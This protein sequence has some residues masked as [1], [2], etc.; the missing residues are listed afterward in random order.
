[1]LKDEISTIEERLD[2][3][4]TFKSQIKE[5]QNET[6]NSRNKIKELE[7]E[8]RLSTNKENNLKDE[9]RALIANNK[10]IKS[11]L[12]SELNEKINILKE[13]ENLKN[14]QKI[15]YEKH[16]SLKN[17]IENTASERETIESKLKSLTIK[18]E[19]L[20]KDLISIQQ[21]SELKCENIF[22]QYQLLLEEKEML[23]DKLNENKFSDDQV[24]KLSD[25]YEE[26]IF[27]LKCEMNVWKRSFLDIANYKLTNFQEDNWE[28][29]INLDKNYIYNCPSQLSDKANGIVTYFK[30]L[31]EEELYKTINLKSLKNSLVEEQEKSNYLKQRLTQETSLRRKIHNR[32]MSIR[33]NLRVMCRVRPFTSNEK[34]SLLKK[35]FLD[36]FSFTTDTISIY[37]K[38]TYDLDYVFTQKSQQSD[39]YEE[40]S[41]LTQSMLQGNNICVI[42]YGQTCTGKTY[43]ILGQELE[44]SF[45]IAVRTAAELFELLS[46]EPH[47]KK[48]TNSN[49]SCISS[50]KLTLSII[51]IYNEGIFN[52]LDSSQTVLNIFENS[53]GNLVIPDLH[54]IKINSFSEAAK[55]FKLAG[56]FR[57]TNS[58]YYNERSSRSHC[59]YTFSVKIEKGDKIIRSKMH[60]IDLAGSERIT[61][62]SYLKDGVNYMNNKENFDNEELIKKEAISINLSLHALSNVLNALSM[63]QTHVPYRESKLTHFLKE[64]LNENFNI[65][66]LL[67]VSPN[68]KDLQESISTLEFGARIVKLCKHKTGKEKMILG[69]S[70]NSNDENK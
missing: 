58:T 15:F 41:L 61:K 38:K 24:Y 2:D 46:K 69:G 63:K 27:L 17:I 28:E 54:P 6:T 12:K 26:E 55:L 14:N 8:R 36:S 22:K 31:I 56:K 59:I 7:D 1:M 37:D 49:H 4:K 19:A 32:Y 51:E 67:H 34:D 20:Q 40:V 62:S 29:V 5:L 35:S 65:L 33:G 18:N 47:H 44:S 70:K 10:K 16:E 11:E 9:I 64:S 3:I 57:H 48:G 23:S 21:Q 13:L 66:L 25:K 43:T 53:S 42:A 52:L 45:G 39:V 60:I 30:S 68:I 50:N